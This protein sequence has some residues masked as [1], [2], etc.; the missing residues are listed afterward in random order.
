MGTHCARMA[1]HW[2]WR[3]GWTPGRR[4]YT[5]HLTFEDAGDVHRYMAAHRAAL[6]HLDGLDLVPDQW[7][8]LTMQALGFTDE[9][10]ETDIE[11]ITAAARQRIAQLPAF[12]L[13]LRTMEVTPQAVMVFAEP[14]EPVQAVRTALREAIAEVWS[15]VPENA[16]RFAPHVTIAYSR[17]TGPAEPVH[18]AVRA[19]KT[20][21]ATARLTRA[22]LLILHRDNRMYEWE[23][24]TDAPLASTPARQDAG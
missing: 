3:P 19:L 2:W 21:P 5:W 14:A 6:R 20:T 9:V 12:D 16:E 18:Q 15:E 13:T 22:Q 7:L 1:D 11:A 17:A 4:L 10:T 24:H 8:H 23:P